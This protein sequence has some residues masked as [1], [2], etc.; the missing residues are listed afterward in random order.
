MLCL[1]TEFSQE[2]VYGY[3]VSVA[4]RVEA[5]LLARFP[6]IGRGKMGPPLLA[7]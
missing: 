2:L 3:P 4:V 1:D 7:R 5:N 6:E